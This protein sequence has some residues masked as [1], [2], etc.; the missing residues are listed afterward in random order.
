MK[1]F[2]RLS[3]YEEVV[4]AFEAWATRKSF[5]PKDLDLKAAF[6]GGVEMIEA[7][8][9]PDLAERSHGDNCY[10]SNQYEGDPGNRCNCGYMP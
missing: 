5:D 4:Q 10:V 8:L 3:T 2:G 9:F 7:R 6:L 1:V